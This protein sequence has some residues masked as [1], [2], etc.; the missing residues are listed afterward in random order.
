[1]IETVHANQIREHGGHLGIR[2]EALLESALARPRHRWS[3]D[4]E[5]VLAALAA[6]YGFGLTKNHAFLDGNKRIGFVAANMFLIL[7]GF[8]IDA[9]EP[10]VV[11]TMLQ[12]A[13]GRMD[14]HEFAAWIRRCIIPYEHD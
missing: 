11:G 1:M 12:V 9:A 7:N 3:Y 13:D 4:E 10:E 14:P 6:E 5:V 2:D 8:E